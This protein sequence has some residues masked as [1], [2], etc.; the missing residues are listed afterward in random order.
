M[1]PFN[2]WS[3]RQRAAAEQG[4]FQKYA[5]DGFSK[6]FRVQVRMEIQE[7]LAR[8]RPNQPGESNNRML[9]N[10]SRRLPDPTEKVVQRIRKELGK[11][12]LCGAELTSFQRDLES[13]VEQS[14]SDD[15]L[16]DTIELTILVCEELF[17]NTICHSATSQAIEELALKLNHR[18]AEH[19]YGYSIENRR[20]TRIDSKFLHQQATEP[21]IQ[22][23]D[24]ARYAGAADEF[25][26]AH[27]LF[28]ERKFD[29]AIIYACKAY[30]SLLKTIF[31]IHGWELPEKQTVHGLIGSCISN[32]LLDGY[33][34]Q[35]LTHLR[36]MLQ[37]SA[38]SPRNNEA[39]HGQGHEPREVPEHLAAFVLHVTAST[40]LFLSNQSDNKL[41]V[42]KTDDAT[43]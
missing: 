8:L 41:E 19:G 33:W 37:S 34:D 7:F 32:G 9:I 12:T 25:S 4:S 10:S 30:E 15:Q 39:A 11:P 27:G 35:H 18:Y 23:L 16:L 6:Q 24:C 2:T 20:I 36:G 43:D 21:A 31:Q 13:F 17:S 5:Y 26:R 3:K 42:A 28:R 14:S 29:T 1:E 38:V 22:L 40:L